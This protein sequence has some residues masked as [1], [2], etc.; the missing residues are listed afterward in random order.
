MSSRML[1]DEVCLPLSLARHMPDLLTPSKR[2]VLQL[3]SVHRRWATMRL[4][5]CYTLLW[6]YLEISYSIVST[7]SK[8]NGVIKTVPTLPI[9]KPLS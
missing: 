2:G 5:H 7:E 9:E 3:Q 1:K 6:S 4:L 8:G